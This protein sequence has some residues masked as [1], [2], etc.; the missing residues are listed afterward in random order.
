MKEKNARI[1]DDYYNDRRGINVGNKR[2]R[3][4]EEWKS[5]YDVAAS[6]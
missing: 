3:I 4:S 5:F 2:E 1:D 6:L